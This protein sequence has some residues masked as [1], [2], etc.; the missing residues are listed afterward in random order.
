MEKTLYINKLEPNQKISDYFLIQKLDRKLDKNGKE[1][2]H[3]ELADNSGFVTAKIWNSNLD[4]CLNCKSGDV[5][6]VTGKTEQFNESLQINVSA[7]QK[8]NE[9][10]N[11]D[12]FVKTSSIDLK[13]IKSEINLFID[14]IS[15]KSLRDFL[16]FQFA[17]KEFS[18]KYFLFSAAKINHHEYKGGLAEHVLEMLRL[19][20][21]FTKI[22]P[23]LN[24]DLIYSGIILHDIGKLFELD[25]NGVKTEY[26]PEGKLLGHIYLGAS[27]VDSKLPEDIDKT[28]RL[29]L[30]HI[31]LSH[32]G[33]L[34]YGSPI[35][36]MIIEAMVVHIVDEAS[37]KINSAKKY[38]DK[39]NT[40]FFTEY[41]SM[42]QTELFIG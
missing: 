28:I 27:W 24:K 6:Y 14:R 21:S 17:D 16:T 29:K 34:E 12:L 1:Y 40:S 36:P 11:F 18:E 41:I 42:L 8:Y 10:I 19:S 4:N 3:L 22:Y 13:E 38:L 25:F 32:H 35:K 33:L 2:I 26:T 5:V 23:N 31:I 37:A 39:N 20:E 7:L 15:N 9:E 30:I